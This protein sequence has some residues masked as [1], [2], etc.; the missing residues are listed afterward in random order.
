MEIV[1]QAK[2]QE[3]CI[4]QDRLSSNRLGLEVFLTLTGFLQADWFEV[5]LTLTGFLQT[6]WFEVFFGQ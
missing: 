1:K 6:D 2:E 4:K 3:I 5:F